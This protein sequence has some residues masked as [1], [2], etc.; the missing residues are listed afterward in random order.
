[1]DDAMATS[2][3]PLLDDDANM[4]SSLASSRM[5]SSRYHLLNQMLDWQLGNVSGDLSDGRVYGG[6]RQAGGRRGGNGLD[7]EGPKSAE[8]EETVTVP[9]GK[10][11]F[12]HI[13]IFVTRH[14][15]LPSYLFLYNYCYHCVPLC[16]VVTSHYYFFCS[17]AHTNILNC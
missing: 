4:T 6:V 3:S 13:P 14:T 9:H 16:T 7:Q 8:V 17:L 1:M 11:D 10:F 2:Q 15:Q 12:L 5:R